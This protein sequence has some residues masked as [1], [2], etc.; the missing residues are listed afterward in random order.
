VR[1]E[2]R[3][4]N[5]PKQPFR[6]ESKGVIVSEELT[7]GG[8]N[9]LLA[10]FASDNP[11]YRQALLEHPKEVVA[12]QMGQTLPESLKVV[13]I[14][15]KPDQFHVVLPYSAAEG[16]EL[17]DADLEQ[18]AG[19]KGGGDTYT[20]NFQQGAVMNFGTRVEIKASLF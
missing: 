16:G 20:C 12:A 8:V 5:I 9:D 3:I 17:S 4:G 18:V 1:T 13:V 2:R 10:G 19:G 7:R 6:E 14:E 15:E 11:E